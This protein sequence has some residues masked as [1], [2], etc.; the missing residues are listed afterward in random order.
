MMNLTRLDGTP[1]QIEASA[2]DAVEPRGDGATVIVRGA[3]VDVKQSMSVVIALR[4]SFVGGVP[5]LITR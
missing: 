4:Q 5:G 3:R 1:I 2:I